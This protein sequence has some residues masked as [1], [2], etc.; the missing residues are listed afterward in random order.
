MCE[1]LRRDDDSAAGDLHV[2][3]RA[4]TG[5]GRDAADFEHDVEARLIGGLAEDGVLPVEMRDAAEADEE[6]RA[7]RIR[8]VRAGHREHAR[9]VQ[10]GVEL[11]LDR[12][13]GPTGTVAERAAD[14][15]HAARDDSVEDDAVVE[16]EFGQADQ[17]LRVSGSDGV[18]NIEQDF[19]HRGLEL[20]LI[21][22][23]VEVHVLQSGIHFSSAI[24]ST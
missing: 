13:A 7:S 23:L 3:F 4:I 8:I 11:L 15:D 2:L 12:V 22:V 24:R 21:G 1:L 5:A 18:R 17:V 9:L 10:L 20:D 16:T 6:L 14:L 19:A